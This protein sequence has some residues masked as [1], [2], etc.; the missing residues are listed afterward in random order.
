MEPFGFEGDLGRE[1][2]R[3]GATWTGAAEGYVAV[4]AFTGGDVDR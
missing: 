2:S 4:G 1:E 3:S